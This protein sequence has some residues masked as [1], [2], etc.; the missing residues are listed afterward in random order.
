MMKKYIYFSLIV[1]NF[2][3]AQIKQY[4]NYDPKLSENA[5][6]IILNE[7]FLVEVKS[8]DKIIYQTKKIYL[9]LNEG[10][11]KENYF[12]EYYDQLNKV[13]NCKATIYSVSGTV[14]KEIK[15]SEFIDSSVSDDVSIFSDDR[16][17]KLDY[18]PLSYPFI[19]EYESVVE[20]SNGAYIIPWYPFKNSNQ[21]IVNAEFTVKN[22]TPD[23]L[24]FNELNFSFIPIVKKENGSETTY[25]CANIFAFKNE[26]LAMYDSEIPYVRVSLT[27]SMVNGYKFN[28]NDLKSF[29]IDFYNNFLK[30]NSTISELTKNKVN[31]LILPS[32]SKIDKIKKVYKYIQDNTRYVSVQVGVGGWKPL[33]IEK[34]EKYGYGDC[35]ALSNYARAILGHL[36][37]ESYYTK[38]YGGDKKDINPEIIAFQGNHIILT[39]P[40]E[41]E[42][43]FLECTSQTNPFGYLGTFTSDRNAL[44]IKPDGAEIVHTTKYLSEENVQYTKANF[45]LNLD[46]S[47]HGSVVIESKNI[48]YNH[49]NGFENQ[50]KKEI[51]ETYQERYNH[52]NNLAVSD[53][54]FINDK[55]I[56]SFTEKFNVNAQNYFTF[57]NNNIL[58]PLNVLNKSELNL[59]KYRNRKF[60]FTL[61]YG[62]RDTDEISIKIPEGYVV[63]S[64]P[65]KI[66]IKEKFGTYSVEIKKN[67]DEIFFKR[68]LKIVD[69][70]YPKE[71]FENY[72]KFREFISRNDNVKL[73]LEK[74]N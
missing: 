30:D 11:F 13:K 51:I 50:D 2:V 14:L 42:M 52:L 49:L 39:V 53:V 36:G 10:G 17:L 7:K 31:S 73:V 32:D 71:E 43:L 15:K 64:I 33:P 69:C 20:S 40:L 34:V 55:S 37:I 68:V 62:Y 25:S 47:I 46:K 58:V 59:A 21:S 63:K 3:S 65:E 9:F 27:N 18:T 61:K 8:S 1:V 5:N 44:M 24:K 72:R 12:Y 74:I 41:K 60:S 4:L 29:G 28:S 23:K 57:E 56:F 45:T 48:Q 54:K 19:I 67:L 26:Q 70:D 38:I 16:I 35:K 22:Q 66:E 6:F